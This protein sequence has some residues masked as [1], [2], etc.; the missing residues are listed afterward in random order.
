MGII[1]EQEKLKMNLEMAG[2]TE[3]EVPDYIV[4]CVLSSGRMFKPVTF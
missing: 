2:G 4:E 3:E 1:G